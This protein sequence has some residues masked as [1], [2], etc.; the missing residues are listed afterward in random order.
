MV[1]VVIDTNVFV[2][3]VMSERGAARKVL[4]LALEGSATP[5]M[6][7]ALL[8][9][10]EDVLGREALFADAPIPSEKRRQLFLA[11]MSV[12]RWTQI[13]YLWRPNLPDESDNHL[14]E[15]AL[16]GGAQVIVSSNTKHLTRG[17]LAFPHLTI[18]T[19]PEFLELM[20]TEGVAQ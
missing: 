11:L 6:G 19:P 14:I 7:N 20:E 13:Y 15:L 12:S 1:T 5:L 2:S 8:C 4:R 16:A 17:G 10:Y 9:E 3:A 18:S